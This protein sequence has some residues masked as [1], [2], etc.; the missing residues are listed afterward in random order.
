MNS[1]AKIIEKIVAIRLTNHLQINKLILNA[2]FGFQKGLSTEHNIIHL[3][4]FI[5]EALNED[6]FCIGIFLDLQKAFDVVSHDIL[7]NKLYHLG[8]RGSTLQ[9]FKSYLSNR[10]QCVEIDGF[11]SKQ[12]PL[13]ISVMQGSVLGP[14]LFICFINDLTNSSDLLKILMFADDTCALDKD[15]D[16]EKLTT[17]CNQELQKIANWF[18]TNKISVKV[19]KCKFILFH[20]PRKKF[21]QDI[22]KISY[23]S[24]EIGNCNDPKNIFEL[25]RVTCNNPDP[26]HHTYK[27]LGIHIDENLN[28]NSHVQHLR[29]KLN[30][31]LFCLNRIKNTLDSK[32]L[33][34]IYFSIFHSHLL[35]CNTIL[36]CTSQTNIN[37]ISVLQKKQSDR[38][39]MQN[40][41]NIQLPYS[42]TIKL[43]R[44]KK[45]W[46]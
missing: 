23:N 33:R 14:L 5:S 10:M 41:I 12:L 34:T 18:M 42:T 40:I 31:S 1:F 39:H 30:K 19:S 8:V 44:L 26:N 9:W 43:C 20:K 46:N 37:C 24:N 29:N 22:C 25:T 28:F 17:R 11:F 21:N 4:N 6:K 13:N 35:Y 27:Y 16:L 32:S 38:Y 2:Q 15:S 3:T 36:N 45:L 7:I